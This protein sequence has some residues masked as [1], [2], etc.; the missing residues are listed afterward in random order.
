M[1]CRYDFHLTDT[2]TSRCSISICS[3]G[4]STKQRKPQIC[5]EETSR[6]YE[7]GVPLGLEG[8]VASGEEWEHVKKTSAE[9]WLQKGDE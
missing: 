3:M 4:E 1:I 9:E 2:G 5:L 6:R 8:E 7:L